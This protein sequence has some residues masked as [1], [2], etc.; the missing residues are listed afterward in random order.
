MSPVSIS[1]VVETLQR[2]ARY[3]DGNTTG[4]AYGLTMFAAIKPG[5]TKALQRYLEDM[6]VGAGSPLARLDHLHCARLHVLEQLVY[7]GAPQKREPLRS[8]YLIF[9]ASFDGDLDRFAQDVCSRL[10]DEADAIFGHCFGYPGSGDPDAFLRYVRHNQIA[11]H[12]VLSPYPHA[13]V[14]DVRQ[15]LELRARVTQ[16]A[17]TNQGADAT[18]LQERFRET[19]SR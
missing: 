8:D 10:P 18:T 13:A 1:G 14:Q 5:E 12:Y 3:L 6:P 17:I 15:G 11:N 4:Q 2:V 16:F 19:F 7:Q 9:T